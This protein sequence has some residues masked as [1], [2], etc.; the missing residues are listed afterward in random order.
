MSS[1][2]DYVDDRGEEKESLEGELMALR[3][4]YSYYIS[5]LLGLL[6]YLPSSS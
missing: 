2:S 3:L 6:L 1:A 4:L 5:F